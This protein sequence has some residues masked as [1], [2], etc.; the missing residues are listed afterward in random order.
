MFLI[1]FCLNLY[2]LLILLEI[3]DMT[4]TDVRVLGQHVTNFGLSA[5]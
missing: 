1:E 3:G 2:I 5:G 4:D